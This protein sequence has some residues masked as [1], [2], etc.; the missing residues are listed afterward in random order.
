MLILVIDDEVAIVEL[1]AELLSDEG[2][3]VRTAYDG[4]RALTLLHNGLRPQVI[5]A[6]PMMPGRDVLDRGLR[7]DPQLASIRV[8]W[9]RA[10]RRLPDDLDAPSL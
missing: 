1:L 6:D 5:M 10:G 4:R 8:I 9:M 3:H 2:H 7:S